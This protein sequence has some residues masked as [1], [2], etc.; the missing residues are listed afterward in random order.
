MTGALPL[1]LPP[2]LAVALVAQVVGRVD[3]LG[4]VGAGVGQAGREHLSAGGPAVGQL[5]QTGE[6][7]HAVHAGAAVQARTR[8]ALVDVHLAQ[9]TWQRER[10]GS[11]SVRSNRLDIV[12]YS[13][14]NG[15]VDIRA[16]LRTQPL[17]PAIPRLATRRSS[18]LTQ[19]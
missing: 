8:R 19:S 13:K 6:A 18:S 1:T 14:H 4:V 9:V 15:H 2:S 7:G 12:L 3:A 10:E 11:R 5:A 17:Q 16:I